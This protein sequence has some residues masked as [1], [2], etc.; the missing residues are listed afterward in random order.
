[1]SVTQPY[2]KIMLRYLVVVMQL[3][4]ISKSSH[5]LVKIPLVEFFGK[6]SITFLPFPMCQF[7]SS[8]LN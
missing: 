4:S 2:F 3:Q 8:F 5:Y 1:V 6:F 7:N